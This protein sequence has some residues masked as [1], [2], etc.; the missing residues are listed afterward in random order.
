L[1]RNRA[2]FRRERK[3]AALAEEIVRDVAVEERDL[4]SA[5][6]PDPEKTGSTAASG[7]TFAASD[8]GS[9]R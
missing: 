5:V 8:A 7:E 6:F 2:A 4:F 3:A 9:G 1:F